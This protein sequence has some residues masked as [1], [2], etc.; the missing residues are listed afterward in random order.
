MLVDTHAHLN[1]SCFNK[2]RDR[3]IEKCLDDNIWIINIGINYETS[4]KAKEIAENYFKSKRIFAAIGLHPDQLGK[5]ETGIK[6]N[7][8]DQ[9]FEKE[10][11]FDFEKYKELAKSKRVKA[12]GEI[13][14]DYWS[15]PKTEKKLHNLKLKQKKLLLEQIKLAQE[16]NLPVI[17]HCRMAHNDLIKILQE[18][19]EAY[20]SEKTKNSKFLKAV[21]HCF[22]GNWRQAQEFLKM[23]FYLGFNGIIFKLNLEK[24]IENT[25]LDRILIE[26]D[27]PFLT[28]PL[29]D[30]F[31][32][33][34]FYNGNHIRN[35]PMFIKHT[36][37]QIAKIKNIPFQK[38]TDITSQNAQR[39]F[40]I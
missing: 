24:V 31:K 3:I 7:N 1:F 27:C 35:E 26:T 21:I 8:V 2:D 14:L 25:P 13:G 33:I 17:F 38:I 37:R 19:R 11:Y 30:K 20:L 12:I 28:P 9:D 29:P 16:L 39:L 10:K 18:Y 5:R 23:G 4:K 6:R 34:K 22:T 36:A 15:K 40:R 32:A